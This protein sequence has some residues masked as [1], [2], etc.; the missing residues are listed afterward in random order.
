LSGPDYFP[1]PAW[2]S[3]APIENEKFVGEIWECACGDGA[4]S[5]VLALSGN[6][7]VSSDLYRRGFGEAG[8]DFL[9]ADRKAA[10]K[11]ALR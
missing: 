5:K 11:V 8:V 6:R 9:A 2:T 10:D 1:T 4:M 7:V 3:H